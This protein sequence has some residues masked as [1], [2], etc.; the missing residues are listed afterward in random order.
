MEGIRF[1]EVYG[2]ISK[3]VLSTKWLNKW[4]VSKSSLDKA[5]K[6]TCFINELSLMISE[7]NFSCVRTLK[8]CK[9]L[10]EELTKSFPKEDLPQDWLNYIYNYTLYKSFPEAVTIKLNSDFNF[11]CEVYLRVLRVISE[12]QR[13]SSDSSFQSKFPLE[14]LTPVEEMNLEDGEEYRRFVKAF[15]QNYI[16][17][18]MKLNSEIT[19]FNTLDHISGVHY[20]ALYIARQLKHLGV[21]VDL[22]RVSGSAAGHDIGKYGCKGAELKRVPYLHYY[23]SDQW[24]KK[25]G[26]N[27]IRNIAINHSTWDLELENLS[28]E[29][30]ILIYSD[31]RVKNQ[32]TEKGDE[33]HIFPLKESFDVILQKLDNVDTAKEKRYRRVYAKLKDFEDFLKSQNVQTEIFSDLNIDSIKKPPKP[34][35]SLMMGKDIVEHIKYLSINHNINLMYMLRDE[36]SL[37][38]ILE[39]ARSETDWKN[40]REYIRIFEEY[41]TYLTQKQKLQTIKFLYENLI[42]PE[43][44]IRRHCAEILGT[45][46][47]IFD[48]EYR[49]E[50]PEKV[51]LEE[52]FAKS[53]DILEEYMNLLLF[54]NHKI[55]SSHRYWLGYSLN[56]MV[57]ALF[58][59]CREDMISNYRSII[60]KYYDLK[61]YKGSE[62]YVFLLE[63][64]KSIPLEPFTEDM[65]LIF[66]FLMSMLKKRN[67]SI[68]LCALECAINMIDRINYSC[69]FIEELKEYIL[70]I[71][72][73]SSY[74]AENM[75][76][77]KIAE[78]LKL[79][80]SIN[81]LKAFYLGGNEEITDIFLSN[82]KTATDWIRKKHQVAL[83][84]DQVM[85]SSEISPIHAAI[86]FCNLL[87]VSAVESVRHE[88]GASILKLMPGLSPSERNEVAIELLRALEIEGHKFTE[89]IPKYLGQVL[90]YLQPK[91][92]DE[93]IEDLI[94]KIKI[95]KPPVKTLILKTSSI[96][97]EYYDEYDTRFDES[98]KK[99]E[100]RLVKIL[101]ILLNG[102]GDYDNKVKQSALSSLGK[103]LFGSKR[104]SLKQKMGFFSL[105]SKKILTL[106]VESKND[107]LMFLSNAAALNHI[108]R[109]ISDYSFFIGEINLKQPKKV[110]FFPGTFDPFSLSHKEIAKRIR[111]LGYEVYL[112]IDE[113]SWSKKPLPNLIR[114][115]IL[116]MSIASELNIFIYPD[117]FPTNIANPKDLKILRENFKESVVYIVVGSDV[118]LNASSYKALKSENS[119]HSF[120][121]IIFERNKPRD[122]SQFTKYIE[123]DV[124]ILLLPSKYT[125]ISSSQIR[126]YIDENR[127]IS[128]LIDPL[129]E[130][131]IYDNGFYQRES[132]D[133]STLAFAH[134]DIEIINKPYEE[135]L[136]TAC[137]MIDSDC[138]EVQD[139]IKDVFSKPSGRALILRNSISKSI[140]AFSLFH[141][142]RSSMIYDEIKDV[143]VADEIRQKSLG[144]II[145]LDGLYIKNVDKN[146]NIEQILLTETLGF[147]I[148]KDYEYALFKYSNSTVCPPY[149]EELLNRFGF[150]RMDEGEHK[151]HIWL[152]N[153][154]TP[155]V[156]NLDLENLI[157]EPFRSN[158]RIKQ[159]L[160]Q[161][162]LKLLE[163]LC[164][165]YPGELV[166]P[167]DSN[168][169]H[170]GLIKK[171]CKENNVPS[172]HINPRIL[173]DAMCVPYGDILDRYVIP[174]TVTKSLHTE[175]YFETDME[176]FS[177]KEFPHYM[178]IE[179]QIRMLKS[180]NRPIILVDNLL[181]KGHRM[182]ALDPLFKREG[183]KVQ[184][185]ITG[186]LSA[187]GKD[188]MD[189]QEREVECVYFIPRL[190][191]WFNENALYPFI[192]GDSLWRGRFPERNL[193][194]S[195]NLIMPY[196][197]PKF[198]KNSSKESV[199]NL[200]KACIEGSIALLE[201]IEQEYHTINERN[202]T[203]SSLGHVFTIPRCPDRGKDMN[204]DL[205]LSP[206]HYLKNDLEL[207]LRL[208]NI[209]GR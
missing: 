9:D 43:D 47:A 88:A 71:N 142:I 21:K 120:S 70:S 184:K 133:K 160:K 81:K 172:E 48:E 191:I 52:P 113:F 119:I 37:D 33:M 14:F 109:F 188:L 155:S 189:Y 6:D 65:E 174:N 130:Q 132:L 194:P 175:K 158:Y 166:L 171:V 4:G 179:N 62:I 23:Y 201:T 95:S 32:R 36:Y 146:K 187:R 111:D 50:I 10:I 163:S 168:M 185:I 115:N 147:C 149:I 156:I 206:S 5:I 123:G 167:F 94:F 198:I 42:H 78:K 83:I 69:K 98:S 96:M 101:G 131:Y 116:N 20:L 16:Y 39:A 159:V 106:L 8:L 164:S 207:L 34:N 77:I 138:S 90:L 19:G 55:I 128:S 165:L 122:L 148:S 44:D 13:H 200:S 203:L 51:S 30:L 35:Y 24:F 153:M 68:R 22:G 143:K 180:F 161:N 127:D 12:V 25:N 2:S 125:D 181:H 105:I 110:A 59:N 169:L 31:F 176:S 72:H 85:N 204:Y 154:S 93:I 104:L 118:I 173:G 99:N 205:N 193:L 17:E 97:A 60:L 75:L 152:V 40:L 61:T 73:K 162:R 150:L 182:Q 124:E 15:K 64:I 58:T 63:N 56:I 54:P 183:I 28:I 49:K 190:K 135:L 108:Y 129:C 89:Y 100:E 38:Y 139:K 66:K 1:S 117:S 140:E 67:T 18:M 112:A 202:L 82:L 57:N 79:T 26:I 114:T 53:F 195:I 87:K 186:V 74:A 144:R 91:E 103:G 92:L 45:L 208:E 11:V 151:Q 197:S 199:Y 41:S 134:L 157:K 192:G 80:E 3:K 209:I 136:E 27:Y 46:I 177:I 196:T 102:L 76:R 84:L 126:N 178:D 86:H 29:S 121:H 145:M 107:E 137:N 141:W 7:K 170:H